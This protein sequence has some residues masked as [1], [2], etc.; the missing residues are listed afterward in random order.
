MAF[1]VDYTLLEELGLGA[2]ATVYK[3]RHN[4]LG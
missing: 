3:V 2:F 4:K 1:L